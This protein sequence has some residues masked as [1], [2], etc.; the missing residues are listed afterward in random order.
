MYFPRIVQSCFTGNED[1]IW[2]PSYYTGHDDVI[3]WKHFPRHWPFVRGIHR[4]PV[5]STHKGQWRWALMFSLICVW[6]NDWVNNREAG[7]L[8]RYRAHYDVSVMWCDFCNVSRRL[9]TNIY[10]L[11]LDSLHKGNFVESVFCLWRQRRTCVIFR[12]LNTETERLPF[13]RNFHHLLHR[14]LSND[15][16]QCSQWWKFQQ[17]D[18]SASVTIKKNRHWTN[19]KKNACAWRLSWPRLSIATQFDNSC[20]SH[21]LMCVG[22]WRILD[23][24]VLRV[25]PD[26]C[27]L[28]FTQIL[29]SFLPFPQAEGLIAVGAICLS[30][31]VHWVKLF[32]LSQCPEIHGNVKK[33]Y[34]VRL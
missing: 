32:A 1:V 25:P 4:S 10:H 7:D 26:H 13:G 18:I 29:M 3:K 33:N 24:N 34:S 19:L 17:N 2:L 31:S 15:N 5:N 28:K 14:K 16:F 30:I 20:L 21:V 27:K 22:L 11:L 9:T 8:R 23:D 12:I 6:I